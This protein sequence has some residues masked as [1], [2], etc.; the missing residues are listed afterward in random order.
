M[1]RRRGRLYEIIARLVAL[2]DRYP[3]ASLLVVDRLSPT[4]L[5]RVGVERIVRVKRDEVVLDDGSVIPLHRVVGVEAG[6][7]R[8]WWRGEEIGGGHGGD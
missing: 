5:R 2:R 4:G 6:G 7:R 3:D 1:G 8:L